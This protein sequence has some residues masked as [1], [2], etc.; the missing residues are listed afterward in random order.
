M[1]QTELQVVTE[2]RTL[3][4]LAI[5][6]AVPGW[7]EACRTVYLSPKTGLWLLLRTKLRQ[8]ETLQAEAVKQL[9]W[10]RPVPW[11]RSSLLRCLENH[12]A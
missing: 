8:A 6:W 10:G 1:L 2:R 12:P 11:V 7:R 4:E 9:D 5:E 3:H